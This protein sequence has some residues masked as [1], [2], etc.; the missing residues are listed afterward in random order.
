MLVGWSTRYKV[1]G[2]RA[3]NYGMSRDRTQAMAAR[4]SVTAPLTTKTLPT[5]H[6][7]KLI[8]SDVPNCLSVCIAGCWNGSLLAKEIPYMHVNN[9]TD[10]NSD[11]NLLTLQLRAHVVLI[12]C[13]LCWWSFLPPT[14]AFTLLAHMVL[15]LALASAFT[16]LIHVVLQSVTCTGGLLLSPTT[17]FTLL[18]HVVVPLLLALCGGGGIMYIY[19]VYY[20]YISVTVYSRHF[21]CA[22]AAYALFNACTIHSNVCACTSIML[23]Q[24]LCK[25][26]A[27][28]CSMQVPIA[29][30][31]ATWLTAVPVT[32]WC[33]VQRTT[34]CQV[35]P[36]SAYYPCG[37]GSKSQWTFEVD[38]ASFKDSRPFFTPARCLY[39]LK[40]RFL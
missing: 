6:K 14:S 15:L 31:F 11:S 26:E 25:N 16:I 30:N 32:F 35:R 17:T 24:Y 12:L 8:Y 4:F 5:E 20:N 2:S 27:K 33:L 7:F 23:A 40:M 39:Q 1:Q 22:I 18:P 34:A 38:R 10:S 37:I 36:P 19:N 9:I 3:K 21:D 13:Y 28:M 29:S